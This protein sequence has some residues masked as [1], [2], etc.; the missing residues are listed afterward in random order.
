MLKLFI[1]VWLKNKASW[2]CYPSLEKCL[3]MYG[4]YN[5]NKFAK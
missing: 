4:E 3:S 1:Y 2:I 5:L